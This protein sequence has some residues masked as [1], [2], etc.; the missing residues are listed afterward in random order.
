MSTLAAA[1]P[2]HG[3]TLILYTCAKCDSSAKCDSHANCDSRAAASSTHGGIADRR[4]AGAVNQRAVDE[5]EC[6]IT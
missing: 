2:A 4:N 3:G 5:R 1:F 6:L